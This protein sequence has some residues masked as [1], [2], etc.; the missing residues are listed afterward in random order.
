MTDFNHRRHTG[1]FSP[2]KFKEGGIYCKFKN[3]VVTLYFIFC[4]IQEKWLEIVYSVLNEEK[5]VLLCAL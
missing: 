5:K 1:A 4:G 2:R 3:N